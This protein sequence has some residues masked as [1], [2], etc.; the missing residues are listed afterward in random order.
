MN[1]IFFDKALTSSD[2]LNFWGNIIG[3]ILGVVGAFCVMLW[4]LKRE[5]EKN[6]KEKID[7]TFFNLLTLF[8]NVKSEFDTYRFI[9]AIETEINTHKNLKRL[10]YYNNEL[11]K[12]REQFIKDI[13]EFDKLTDSIYKVYCSSIK[14]A[15][16]M[17]ID[18]GGYHTHIKRLLSLVEKN[19]QRGFN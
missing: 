16:N 7:N 13:D 17:D 3:S 8:Q 9:K 5:R 4:Q 2:W 14:E 10:N 19:S 18:I 15:L 11:S 12:R 1:I 6:R